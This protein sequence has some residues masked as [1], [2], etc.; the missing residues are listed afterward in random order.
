[1]AQQLTNLTR[2]HEDAASTPA[3]AQWVKDQGLAVSHGVG[4][5]CGSDPELLCAVA[6]FR[7]LA[8]KLPH[9]TSMALKSK[10]KKKVIKEN[11]KYL[12]AHS[13]RNLD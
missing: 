1:M 9:A 10:K 11:Y 8:W 5:R 12:C 3:L 6:T 7:P 4:C 13:L 2:I